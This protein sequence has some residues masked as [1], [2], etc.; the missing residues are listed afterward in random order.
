MVRYRHREWGYGKAYCAKVLC[1]DI[2]CNAHYGQSG[3]ARYGHRV[4]G[5]SL[6]CYAVS[7]IAS[8]PVRYT[9]RTWRS[10]LYNAQY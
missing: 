1:V 10:V 8:G 7:A 6:C 9:V 5:H 3:A 2:A 4:Y